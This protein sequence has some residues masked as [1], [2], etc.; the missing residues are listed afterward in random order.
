M[1]AWLGRWGW[2]VAKALLA[3]AILLGVGREFAVNLGRLDLAE[4][5]V[6]PAWLALSAALY[7]LALAGSAWYWYHLLQVF[8]E[9]PRLLPTFRAYYLGHLGKYVPGK[10]WALLLRGQLVRG[11]GTDV[12][13]GVAIIS[14]F[15]RC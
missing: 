7:V 3:V 8:G 6:Q 5:T 11:P 9:R 4:L 1:K 13:L 14:A 2:P 10:A 12:R 15:L